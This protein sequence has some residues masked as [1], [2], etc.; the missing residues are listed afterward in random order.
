MRFGCRSV[1]VVV[2]A[3]TSLPFIHAQSPDRIES[4]VYSI[5]AFDGQGY[6]HTFSP[7][8]SDKL[9][10]IANETNALV[11]RY[12]LTYFW[13]ITGEQQIDLSVLDERPNGLIEIELSTGET[14][15][16]EPTEFVY[17][18]RNDNTTNRWTLATGKEARELVA[19]YQQEMARYWQEY[20]EYQQR[21]QRYEE[22]MSEL[23][24]E[25][26]R[27]RERGE[28]VDELVRA[29]QK[30]SRPVAPARPGDFRNPPSELR[31]GYPVNL[32]KGVHEMRMRTEHG[33][34]IEGS[35][36]QIKAISPRR[37]G[38]VGYELIPSDRWT[39]RQESDQPGGVLYVSEDSELYFRFFEQSEY[40]DDQYSRLLRNDAEEIRATH[41]WVRHGD[42]EN[43]RL[44]V[45]Y[46]DG[47]SELLE[48]R[49]Y[50]VRQNPGRSLGYSIVPADESQETDD[51][52][53]IAGSIHGAR[54]TIPPGTANME[55]QVISRD[56]QHLPGSYRQVRILTQ[57]DRLIG[58]WVLVFT[59]LV[60]FFVV[61]RVRAARLRAISDKNGR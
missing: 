27:R 35:T 59:P 50:A 29:M 56:G 30:A 33:K 53:N 60:V 22:L 11:P 23:F 32:P 10:V 7:E 18:R 37:S 61:F 49:R 40:R 54:L 34:I 8:S 52:H 44:S 6:N 21:T 41:R 48:Q 42:I 55:L 4:F 39:R 45:Q 47:T 9:Y 28:D 16:S 13:P 12:T 20:G 3:L 26:A 17:Y 31:E 24:H 43:P 38:F 14:V 19:E 58:L 46:R 2:L 51:E 25:V 5:Y 57:S 15:T 36:R 1:F